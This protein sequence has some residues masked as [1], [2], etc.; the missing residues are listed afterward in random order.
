MH[1]HKLLIGQVISNQELIEIFK[2]GNMGGM[3]RSHKTKSLILVNDHTK[4][5]YDDRWEDGIC[6]LT[7]MGLKG[8]QT[9]S[10]QNKTLYESNQIDIS[11]YLFEVHISNQYRFHGQVKLAAEPFQE[12]QLDENE[13]IRKVWVFPLM[14]LATIESIPTP[15]EELESLAKSRAKRLKQLSL[16]E[17]KRRA[18]D[19]PKKPSKAISKSIEYYRNPY[20][21]EYVKLRANGHCE[22]C[23]NLGPFQA[24]NS[25]P[26]LEVHHIK[27]LANNGDDTIENTTALCPNCHRKM[28]VINDKNDIDKLLKIAAKEI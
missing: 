10:S 27:W 5:V 13:K 18:K 19:S 4:G 8:D 25:L 14:P 21:I 24:E 15:K 9:L 26:F 1:D 28:H 6:Y 12:D 23:G 2:V 3:R 22:L 17:I 20:V 16:A 11:V 7:G